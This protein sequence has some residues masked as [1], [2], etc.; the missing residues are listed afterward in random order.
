[1]VSAIEAAPPKKTLKNESSITYTP[2]KNRQHGL[3]KGS[4]EDQALLAK[5]GV[6]AKELA[7]GVTP[8]IAG[9]FD[10]NGYLDFVLFG[11]SI[12]IGNYLPRPDGFLVVRYKNEQII[13]K[14][15]IKDESLVSPELYPA[16]KKKGKFGEPATERDGFVEW[17]EGGTTELYLYNL[18]TRQFERTQYISGE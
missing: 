18:K 11:P 13:A 15:I 14:D 17:G 6:S 8:C 7:A 4:I 1:M 16:T 5:A 3:C 10:G 9:D 12:Q 2:S